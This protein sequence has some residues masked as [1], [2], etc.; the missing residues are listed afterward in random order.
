M[1]WQAYR[2][3]EHGDYRRSSKHGFG[4]SVVGLSRLNVARWECVVRLAG[5]QR[6]I[7]PVLQNR[8]WASRE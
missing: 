3:G 1:Q 6:Q 4:Y 8:Q 2:C 7:V 5:R